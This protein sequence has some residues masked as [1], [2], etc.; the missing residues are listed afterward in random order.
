MDSTPQRGRPTSY[1][2]EMGKRICMAISQS[3]HGLRK[4]LEL[5]PELPAFGCVQMWLTRHADF[6]QGYAHAKR[7]QVEAMADDIIDISR[8]E[9]LDPGDKRI[10]VDTLKWILS[11]LIPKTYGDKLDVTS[12]GAAL[13]APA[14]QIDARVQS[15]IMQAQQRKLKGQGTLTDEAMA[16]LE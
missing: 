3:Q 12:D 6:A 8:D 1:T 2:P 11:K 15:I 10:Q 9:S 4:T 14:H 13:A 7:L 5:D 16:L